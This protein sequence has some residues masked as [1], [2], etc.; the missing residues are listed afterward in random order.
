MDNL[1]TISIITCFYNYDLVLFKK[2]LD[3]IKNQNYPQK[4]IEHIILD[5][6]SKLN[7]RK[8]TKNYNTHLIIK[9][10][11][12]NY[13]HIRMALGIKRA[14]NKLILILEPDNIIVGKNWLREMVQPFIDD[15]KIFCTFSMYNAYDPDMPLLVKYCALFGIPD[16][17]LYYLKKSEKVPLFKTKYDKGK[18]IKDFKKYTVVEFNLST[19]P[20]LGDNGHMFRANIIKIVS[21][22]SNTF[23]HTD[24]VMEMVEKGNIK[25][26]VVKNSIIHLTEKNIFKL[27]RQRMIIKSKFYDRLRGKRKYLVYDPKS[28]EDRRNILLYIFFSLTLI[29]PLLESIRGFVVRREAAWFLHPI[30]CITMVIAYGYS[31]LKQKFIKVQ[32]PYS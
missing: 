30:V 11:L 19:L 12:Q 27:A 6:G 13:P 26:G 2:H 25:V 10:D 3:A 17:T 20:T 28:Q 5:G 24:V 29:V 31:E 14:K 16:P 8:V 21:H 15:Q 1:P 4:N 18:I 9:K 23:S 32:K 7:I 22:N